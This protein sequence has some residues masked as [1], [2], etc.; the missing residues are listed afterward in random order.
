MAK[1][2]AN[3]EGWGYVVGWPLARETRP[4]AGTR[5]ILIGR[6]LVRD[7]R[8]CERSAVLGGSSPW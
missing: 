1:E 2:K 8:G 6:P 7:L 4:G 3:A 5:G